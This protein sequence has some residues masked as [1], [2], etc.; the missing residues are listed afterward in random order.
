M[1]YVKVTHYYVLDISSVLV[2]TWPSTICVLESLRVPL[3]LSSMVAVLDWRLKLR[4]LQS[5]SEV[6]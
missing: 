3:C 1:S 2:G 5:Q 6:S 4:H